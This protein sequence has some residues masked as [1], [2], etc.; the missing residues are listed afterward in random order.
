MAKSERSPQSEGSRK[1]IE[2]ASAVTG[3]LEQEVERLLGKTK[4]ADF[5]IEGGRVHIVRTTPFHLWGR[6][7]LLLGF[8][9]N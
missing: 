4:D 7:I 8:K 6:R 3:G 5:R 2:V 1:F 9:K